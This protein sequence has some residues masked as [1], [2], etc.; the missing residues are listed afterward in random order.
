M[1]PVMGTEVLC[2]LAFIWENDVAP[3]VMSR[4]PLAATLWPR[5]KMSST[6]THDLVLFRGL[7]LSTAGPTSDLSDQSDAVTD[8]FTRGRKMNSWKVSL[9]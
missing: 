7:I 4:M 3:L 1:L 2:K 8:R 6:C 9:L 5:S